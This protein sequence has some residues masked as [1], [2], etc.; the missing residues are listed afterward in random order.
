MKIDK[1]KNVM[2]LNEC[3]PIHKFN[4]ELEKLKDAE[5]L[6]VTYRMKHCE[7]CTLIRE[8]SEN[9]Q[10]MFAGVLARSIILYDYYENALMYAK[11]IR[12]SMQ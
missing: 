12:E 3:M 2:K 9:E 1:L 10:T 11:Q 8:F 4:K 6:I 7:P 5:H